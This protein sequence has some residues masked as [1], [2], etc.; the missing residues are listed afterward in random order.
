MSALD[1]LYLVLPWLSISFESQPVYKV[2]AKIPLPPV[3]LR[4]EP[5]GRK[6]SR[7]SY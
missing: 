4:M 7:V 6:L 5:L 1:L 3:F 2:K